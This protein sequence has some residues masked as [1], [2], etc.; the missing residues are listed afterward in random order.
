MG[1]VNK[2]DFY[3]I[4]SKGK[5]VGEIIYDQIKKLDKFAFPAWGAKNF[6][7]G[8]DNLQFDVRGPKHKGRVM[9]YYDRAKDLYDI[10]LGNVRQ[11]EWKTK[12]KIK[13]VF[14][15]DLV[16]ILDQHIG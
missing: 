6:M 13:Q 10:E 12:R 9:I 2:L 8:H 16:N 15:G 11:L 7:Q 3:L 5:K 4:E 1:I 14:A